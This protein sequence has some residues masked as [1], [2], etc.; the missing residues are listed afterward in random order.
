[1]RQAI[2][3]I[4]VSTQKQATVGH[5]LDMQRVQIEAYA[6]SRG[7]RIRQIIVDV[8]SGM[9]DDPNAKFKEAREKAVKNNWPIIVAGFD[10][11]ARNTKAFEE[12]VRH[13]GLRIISAQDGEGV[14]P[15]VVQAISVRAEQEGKRISETTKAALAER[16]AKGVKL[17]NRKNLSDAQRKG[18]AANSLQGKHRRAEFTVLAAEAREAGATN[19]RE[20]AN[21][22]N[23]KG[24]KTARGGEWKPSNVHR[25]L[26]DH[27]AP[28][29][30]SSAPKR[31]PKAPE[32]KPLFDRDGYPLPG[33]SDRI[34]KI[35]EVR[36]LKPGDVMAETGFKRLDA[37]LWNAL[38]RRR[39]VNPAMSDKVAAWVNANE[40]DL[41]LV[42]N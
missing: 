26:Q 20:I 31:P 25:M 5:G 30:R 17:G 29:K 15:A 32:R 42:K 18:A 36:S 16:K 13:S 19:A 10:R 8:A 21:Y 24:L 3:Y 4:R 28:S 34:S 41:G 23:G 27:S 33:A 11:I 39:R 6:Q 2:G 12:A 37:A 9:G 40:I 14:D 35:M 7:I 1:M 22:L 38:K